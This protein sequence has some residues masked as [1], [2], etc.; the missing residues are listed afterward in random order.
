[1]EAKDKAVELI[2]CYTQYLWGFDK[3]LIKD[4]AIKCSLVAVNEIIKNNSELLDGLRYHEELNY[5]EEVK[6]EI[7]KL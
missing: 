3:E 2:A 5:W 4:Q 6:Q 7:Y 1:M